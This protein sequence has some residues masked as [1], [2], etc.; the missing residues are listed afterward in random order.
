M[1]AEIVD[2]RHVR[3]FLPQKTSLERTVFLRRHAELFCYKT[4]QTPHLPGQSIRVGG[5]GGVKNVMIDMH[6]E[7]PGATFRPFFKDEK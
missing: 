3:K 5:G 6:I 4:S 7:G 2:V 1:E